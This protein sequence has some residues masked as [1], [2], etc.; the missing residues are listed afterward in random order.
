LG[1]KKVCC[2]QKGGEV[3]KVEGQKSSGGGIL[4]D[5]LVQIK[6]GQKGN[7]MGGGGPR[8]DTRG[9]KNSIKGLK[10]RD[11]DGSTEN[12]RRFQE[13]QSGVKGGRRTG[14]KWG[15]PDSGAVDK[16]AALFPSRTGSRAKKKDNRSVRTWQKRE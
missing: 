6:R 8:G 15:G 2:T 5:D 16:D 14:A 10:Q 11:K 12:V 9:R 1:A 4:E 3:G 13:K 7:H